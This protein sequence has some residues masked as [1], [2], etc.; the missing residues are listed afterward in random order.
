MHTT[1]TQSWNFLR[2]K[3]ITQS[4]SRWRDKTHDEKRMIHEQRCQANIMK[5]IMR[6]EVPNIMRSNAS[7]DQLADTLFEVRRARACKSLRSL[8]PINVEVPNQTLFQKPM[9]SQIYPKT[10]NHTRNV[11]MSSSSKLLQKSNFSR[12]KSS[13]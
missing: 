6:V 11:T 1:H 8:V 10:D 12:P 5:N 3:R 9:S 4:G 2:P 7:L 13:T